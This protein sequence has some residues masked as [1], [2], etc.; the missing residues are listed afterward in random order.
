MKIRKRRLEKILSIVFRTKTRSPSHV[1]FIDVISVIISKMGVEP[2][3]SKYA[4]ERR[5]KSIARC[6]RCY[7]VKPGFYFTKKCDGKT[8]V[9]GLNHNSKVELYIKVASKT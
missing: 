7:R 1:S 3:N 5:A 8:C 4:R 6:P 9:P 2:G